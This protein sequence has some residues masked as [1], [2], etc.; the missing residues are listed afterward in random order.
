MKNTIFR[1]LGIFLG[2]VTMVFGISL[3]YSPV[4][5]TYIEVV[6]GIVGI[7]VGVV[8]IYFGLTGRSIIKDIFRDKQ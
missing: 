3:L 6:D 4:F 8:F 1:C 5:E 7:G 2:I